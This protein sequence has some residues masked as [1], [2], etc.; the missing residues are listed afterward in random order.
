[1]SSPVLIGRRD[2]KK[3]E[4]REALR[5]AALQLAIEHGYEQL[6]VEAITE[7]ADVSV[8]TFFN[9]FTSKDDALLGPD[10][11]RA[12][13]LAVGL[14]AR[15]AGE[16]PV[17]ALR[18]VFGDLAESF[19]ERE[20]MWRARLELVRANPQLWPRMFAGFADFERVLTEAVA[21][22]TGCDPD[23]DLYPGVVAAAVVGAMRVAMAHWRAA[24]GETSLSNLLSAAYNIL[25]VGLSEP[26]PCGA[27][28]V[29][30]HSQ[31]PRGDRSST[32]PDAVR[33]PT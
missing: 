15:P 14:A 32:S 25:A 6:T 19:V 3:A 24:S 18:A 22:R 11:D 23:V 8:R 9:Y 26:E 2:R 31:R 7:S 21:T 27:A 13:A 10:P 30:D 29:S 28:Q 16:P 20:P 5:S 17:V 1:M 12:D 33:K 4:T